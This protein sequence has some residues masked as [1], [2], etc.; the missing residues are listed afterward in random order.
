MKGK[1][2]ALLLAAI[3]DRDIQTQEELADVLGAEGIEVTQATISRDIK[4]LGL[5][6]IPMPQGGYRYALPFDRA[7]N[8][9]LKQ[10]ER[11]FNDSV[12]GIDYAENLVM[13][14]TLTG[15]APAVAAALDELNWR[16][17]VGTIAGDDSA[18]VI[19]RHKQVVEAL[20]EKLHKLRR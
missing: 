19:V 3:K 18:L 7:L 10:A 12:I 17:V 13:I 8:D 16:E 15:R 5:V 20:V 4:E 6:K 1:R 2:H 11:I 9:V 14:K